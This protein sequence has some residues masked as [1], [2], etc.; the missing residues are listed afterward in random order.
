MSM[1]ATV[2]VTDL[3]ATLRTNRDGH[4][5]AYLTAKAG[6]IKV[7]TGQLTKYVEQLADG[8][9]LGP[10][11]RFLPSPPEDHTS[12][13][14]TAIA[15]MEWTNDT[16]IELSQPMFQQY[17]LDDWNWKEAWKTSNATYTRAA[18]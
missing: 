14:D 17:V 1:T 15:M 3:L 12:D 13:Y 11:A 10:D 8:E 18:Q 16:T 5:D 9:L 2:N 4:R 6:Y 7:V